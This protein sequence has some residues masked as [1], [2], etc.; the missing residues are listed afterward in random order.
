MVRSDLPSMIVPVSM[1]ELAPCGRIPA[2]KNGTKRSGYGHNKC[3]VDLPLVPFRKV[4]LIAIH[5]L[6]ESHGLVNP[7]IVI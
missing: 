2:G 6:L 3:R 1:F 4:E 7:E 5:G